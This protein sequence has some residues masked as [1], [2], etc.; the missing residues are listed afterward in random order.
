MMWI[1]VVPYLKILGL[2]HL[3][4]S[5]SAGKRRTWGNAELFKSV[6]HPPRF[7]SPSICGTSF[8]KYIF[9]SMCYVHVSDCEFLNGF[10][11]N[12]IVIIV[13]CIYLLPCFL[14]IIILSQRMRHAL[15]SWKWP[16]RYHEALCWGRAE[17]NFLLLTCGSSHVPR[18]KPLL[19]NLSITSPYWYFLYQYYLLP[20]L[21]SV[22]HKAEKISSTKSEQKALCLIT[23]RVCYLSFVHQ[24]GKTCSN[25]EQI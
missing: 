6:A 1:L 22:T 21:K 4:S 15:C 19:C 12:I 2:V 11:I 3:L 20:K 7:N 8:L 9:L 24:A 16:Q 14:Q 23:L 5:H 25:G 10:C 17:R 13:A 18:P